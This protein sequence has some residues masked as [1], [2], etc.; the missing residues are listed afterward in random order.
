[1]AASSDV[2]AVVRFAAT[3]QSSAPS[4]PWAFRSGKGFIGQVNR[5]HGQLVPL[6]SGPDRPY[7]EGCMKAGETQLPPGA[8]KLRLLELRRPPA[9][10]K[11]T[12][13][14]LLRT[15]P[16]VHAGMEGP[17]PSQQIRRLNRCRIDAYL[18]GRRPRDRKSSGALEIRFGG[19]NDQLLRGNGARSNIRAPGHM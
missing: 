18:P 10:P 5:C 9:Q 17:I 15:D 14:E 8:G 1:M 3:F 12:S 4:L 19:L 16:F 2:A 6:E 13:K 7:T 11:R